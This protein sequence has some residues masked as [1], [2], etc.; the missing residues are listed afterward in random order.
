MAC[1]DLSIHNAPL[2]AATR[3]SLKG[4]TPTANSQSFNGNPT[5][6][7]TGSFGA[8][9]SNAIGSCTIVLTPATGTAVNIPVTVNP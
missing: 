9:T 1:G 8:I 6:T 3:L 4:E 7:L 5:G 2:L